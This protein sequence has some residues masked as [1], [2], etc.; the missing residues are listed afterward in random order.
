[1]LYIFKPKLIPRAMKAAEW[2]SFHDGNLY[3]GAWFYKKGRICN[4]AVEFSKG[5]NTRFTISSFFLYFAGYIIVSFFSLT[6]F[7]LL[8]K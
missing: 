2:D 6:F 1:M 8:Q 5:V 4:I 3:N 7:I